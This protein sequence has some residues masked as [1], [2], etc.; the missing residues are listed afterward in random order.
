MTT[1]WQMKKNFRIEEGCKYGP[2]PETDP[3]LKNWI[4]NGRKN[5]YGSGAAIYGSAVSIIPPRYYTSILTFPQAYSSKDAPALD[6]W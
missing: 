3:C 6:V 1:V 5:V 4:E 2:D